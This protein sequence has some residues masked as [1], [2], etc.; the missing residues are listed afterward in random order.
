MFMIYNNYLYFIWFLSN[1][2]RDGASDNEERGQGKMDILRRY[3]LL[4]DDEGHG[5]SSRGYKSKY[6][7]DLLHEQENMMRPQAATT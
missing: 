7:R 6:V 5:G 3:G 2:Q 4:G 1:E